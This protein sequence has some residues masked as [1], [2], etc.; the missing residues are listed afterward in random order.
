MFKDIAM[1]AQQ[2][3]QPIGP[4]DPQPQPVTPDPSPAP[5]QPGHAPTEV[6]VRE[7]PG[8]PTIDPA[9]PPGPGTDPGPGPG[10]QSPP[11][12]NDPQPRA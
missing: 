3:N 7:P 4:Y 5:P 1:A 12:P 8:I 2:P 6:P 10:P 9:R 11:M